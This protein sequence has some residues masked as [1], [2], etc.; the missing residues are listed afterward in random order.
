MKLNILKLSIH[1]TTVAYLISY[2]NS[3]NTL[4]FDPKYSSDPNRI[5]FS[6]TGTANF[7]NAEKLISKPQITHVRLHPI[8][9]NLLPEGDLRDLLIKQLK[10]HT[11][12]EFLLFS[13]LGHDLPGAI[14]AT[15]TSE[16]PP[17]LERYLTE[18]L[19]EEQTYFND[20]SKRTSYLNNDLLELNNIQNK[21]SLAGIQIKFSV[22]QQ[23]GRYTLG[24]TNQLGNWI[25]KT[26]S[27]TYKFLPQNEYTSMRLAEI[28]GVDIPEI[29][30]INLN[31]IDNIPNINLPDEQYAYGIKR[32]DRNKN[33]RIH[34]E[35]F[36]QILIKYPNQKYNGGNY[37]QIGQIIYNYSAN[38]I[39]DIQQLTRR[40]LVNILLGNGDAHLKNWSLIY[41][42]R[43]VPMLSPAYDIVFTKA[44]IPT[45]TGSALNMAKNKKWA[46]ANLESFKK[47][48]KNI[49]V[50]W[51][52]IE[53]HFLDVL[54]IAK[55]IWPS[56]LN[57]MPMHN[58]HKQL[59]IKHWHSLNIY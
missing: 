50:D 11:D 43:Y 22:T 38:P 24:N 13:S 2:A 21:F 57:N 18:N 34:M 29:K 12:N 51:R 45:E 9:S 47:W 28:A 4:I 30:L 15:Q 55:T 23:K 32:F 44:Y 33:Q 10:I 40:L 42:D 39:K 25:I 37:E 1:H 59:L 16:I 48:A 7:P 31:K 19:I 17:F 49:N 54:N 52:I 8:L 36:G 27:A 3:K 5:T 26:P 14:V 20:K 58:E 46:N 6:L 53:P 35:D 41:P 56:E